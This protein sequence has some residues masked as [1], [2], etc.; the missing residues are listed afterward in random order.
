MNHIPIPALPALPRDIA[1][2]K[3]AAMTAGAAQARAG[4]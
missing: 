4:L 1:K 2:G 3:L